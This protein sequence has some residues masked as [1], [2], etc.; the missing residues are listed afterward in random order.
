MKRLFATLL[1]LCMVLGCMSLAVFAEEAETIALGDMKTVTV[2]GTEEFVDHYAYYSFTPEESGYYAFCAGGILYEDLFR[3]V[4]LYLESD[5]TMWGDLNNAMRFYAEAGETYVLY[6]NIWGEYPPE[7]GEVE[8]TFFL[9]MCQP[10]E[11]F[12]LEPDLYAGIPGDVV[13]IQLVGEP[14]PAIPE[15][16]VWE[17]SDESLAFIS[18]VEGDWIAL[19]LL[20]PGEVTVTATTESGLHSSVDIT[21]EEGDPELWLVLGE[22]PVELAAYAD[23]YYSFMP[24]ETGYYM[25][26]ADDENLAITASGDRFVVDGNEYYY[27]EAGTT[28]EVVVMSWAEE[29]VSAIVTIACDADLVIPTPVAIELTKAPNNTAYLSDA[30]DSVSEDALFGGMEMNVTWQDGSVTPWSYD[31]TWGVG[32]FYL[33][34]EILPGDEE[35]TAKLVVG[36]ESLELEPVIVDITVLD[37]SFEGIELVDDTP[38]QIVENSCGLDLEAL[39]GGWYYMPILAYQREVVLHFSDESTVTAKPGDV[40]YGQSVTCVDSQVFMPWVKGGD[41]TIEYGYGD[42]EFY[43][44]LQVEII[45]SPV[46]SVEFVTEPPSTFVADEEVG[47]LTPDGEA[48]ES[49]KDL[50][51]G[52]SLKVTY[53][54]G[55][56]KT[57]TQEDIQWQD[58]MGDVYPFMD[59]YPFGILN[60]LLNFGTGEENLIPPCEIEYSIEY[61]GASAAYTVT[62][63]AELPEEEEPPVITEPTEPETEP[64][65]PETEPT[66]PDG[67]QNPPTGESDVYILLLAVL[68]MAVVLVTKMLPVY[69]KK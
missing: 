16:I 60:E 54:D 35:G 13:Y 39:G 66:V 23:N 26:T 11:S 69:I 34:W 68:A 17:V 12:Y 29:D 44:T 59:G 28:Y 1:M 9:E 61:M 2:V 7:I 67:E 30:L 19:D 47:L 24:E 64:T 21:I 33:E 42:S 63:L 36:L 4:D 3:G 15:A 46:E 49:L 8:Y 58:V 53:K 55:T 62:I 52:M 14:W 31:M 51:E 41:N 32:N 57:F 10:L 18:Y 50:F 40:V 45:D 6:A 20:A 25:I 65:E 5:E 37:I 48:V 43:A 56:S 27:M 38:L 22:N